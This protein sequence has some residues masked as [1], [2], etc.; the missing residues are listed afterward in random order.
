MFPKWVLLTYPDQYQ[1]FAEIG[2]FSIPDCSP[3]CTIRRLSA[4]TRVPNRE[5][6]SMGELPSF[7]PETQ[8]QRGCCERPEYWIR[9]GTPYFFYKPFLHSN[10]TCPPMS[11]LVLSMLITLSVTSRPIYNFREWHVLILYSFTHIPGVVIMNKVAFIFIFSLIGLALSAP[12]SQVSLTGDSGWVVWVWGWAA[13]EKW[14]DG[15]AWWWGVRQQGD[16]EAS[17]QRWGNGVEGQRNS[18]MAR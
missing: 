12:H 3:W 13:G 8:N 7:I 6:R 4:C 14:Y 9:P 16:S 15:L 18:R 11:L 1:G 2:Q 17:W 5:G 10:I